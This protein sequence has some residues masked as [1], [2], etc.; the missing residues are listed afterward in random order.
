MYDAARP[1]QIFNYRTTHYDVAPTL[2]QEVFGC[3]NPPADYSIGQ[4]VFDATPRP[5]SIFSDATAKAIRI[6]DQILVIHNFEHVEQY[7]P[8]LNPLPAAPNPAL[9]KEALKTFTNF[10]K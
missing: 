1:H 9:V 4:N 10:Y 2:L 7:D 8:F 6:G 5:Y 3:Q